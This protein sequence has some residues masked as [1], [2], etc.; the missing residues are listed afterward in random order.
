MTVPLHPTPDPSEGLPGRLRVNV[1]ASAARMMIVAPLPGVMAEHVEV[2][3]DGNWLT[4][5]AERGAEADHD[6]ILHEWNISALQRELELPVDVG[7]PVTAS[8]ANGQLTIT[9]ARSRSGPAEPIV[10]TPSGD[11]LHAAEEVSDLIDLR[12]DESVPRPP[13]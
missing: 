7:W 2:V 9:L 4:I 13:R 1:F 5:R 12:A 10:I 3:L 11:R 8:L 6:Y